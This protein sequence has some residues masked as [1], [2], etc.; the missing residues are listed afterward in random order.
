MAAQ[1]VFTTQT[2]STTDANDSVG[3]ALGTRIITAVAGTVLGM[4]WFFPSTVPTSAPVGGLYRRTSDASGTLLGS[5][6]FSGYTAGAWCTQLFASPVPVTAGD[7]LVA[8]VYTANHYVASG[9][10]FTGTSVVSGDLTAPADDSVTPARNGKFVTPVASIA[11]PTSS[12]NGGCYF[13]DV[14]FAADVT[15][16]GAATVPLA[17][18]DGVLDVTSTPGVVMAGGGSALPALAY[19]L[20][21]PVIAVGRSGWLGLLDIVHSNR[22]EHAEAERVAPEACPNDG[23]PLT[24]GPDNAILFCRYCGWRSRIS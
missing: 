12:F 1:S 11:Y 15:L 17:T 13:V 5:V 20:L 16:T 7:D 21:D 4:R 2:P 19:G 3:Y 6:T 9:G 14:L 10:F 8:V 22:G 24:T 18:A 23:E